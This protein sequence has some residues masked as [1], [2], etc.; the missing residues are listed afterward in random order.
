MLKDVFDRRHSESRS[1]KSV[2]PKRQNR[3][4]EEI[5]TDDLGVEVDID[6]D[7]DLAMKW[8]D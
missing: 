8:W 1:T 6:T 5:V 3:E 2:S 4:K 7:I